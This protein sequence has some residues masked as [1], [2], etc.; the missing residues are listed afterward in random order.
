MKTTQLTTHPR[1]G[2]K[3]FSFVQDQRTQELAALVSQWFVD[4][5][6]VRPVGSI[7]LRRALSLYWSHLQSLDTAPADLNL[8]HG[9]GNP[10]PLQLG[11]L[12]A[13]EGAASGSP[14]SD[15]PVS[16]RNSMKAQML[17]MKLK[18]LGYKG[19]QLQDLVYDGI[20]GRKSIAEYVATIPSPIPGEQQ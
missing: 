16:M 20:Q 11:E 10:Y 12:R 8:G 19:Q 6:A 5:L 17:R 7:T 13:I 14:R 4:R 1:P 3:K 2:D 9:M 15:A 18:G